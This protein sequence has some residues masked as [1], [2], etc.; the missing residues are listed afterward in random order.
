MGKPEKRFE[1]GNKV[2]VHQL[3]EQL[4]SCRQN[5]Q[6]LIDYYGRLT[7]MWEEL[8]T[9]KPPPVCSCSAAAI[10][11][12]FIMGLDDSKFSN[13]VTSII[14]AYE[15]PDL[16]KAYAKVIREEARL[17]TA[18]SR[19]VE[20]QEAIGFVSRKEVR[21]EDSSKSRGES[22]DGSNLTTRAE[23]TNGGYGN[24]FKDRVCSHCG[25]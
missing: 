12:Q 21:E 22:C 8:Q 7:M 10:Y 13:V 24:R 1:V 18:T 11:D 15:L 4:A 9:Y 25:K 16:G 20:Q 19:E 17:N 3:I 14:E 2:C 5:G 6:P 23:S